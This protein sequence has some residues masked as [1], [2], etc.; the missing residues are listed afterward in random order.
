M[1]D[2]TINMFSKQESTDLKFNKQC[3][4]C[5]F[6]NLST[7]FIMGSCDMEQSINEFCHAYK[8][9][10]PEFSLDL[11]RLEQLEKQLKE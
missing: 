1:K 8:S 5:R 2:T 6:L 4:I 11:K 9:K 7:C 3:S 10:C